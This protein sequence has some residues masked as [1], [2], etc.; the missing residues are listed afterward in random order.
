MRLRLTAFVLGLI[1][2]AALLGCSSKPPAEEGSQAT[3]APGTT[4]GNNGTTTTASKGT[5]ANNPPNPSNRYANPV[6]R[7]TTVPEGTVLHVRLNETL[8]SKSSNAGQS[9][10]AVVDEPV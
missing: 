4:A 10:S 5:N 2:L 6:K 1:L 9:F 8:S 7:T 3:P